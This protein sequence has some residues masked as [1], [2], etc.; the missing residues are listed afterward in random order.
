VGDGAVRGALDTY[1]TA[2]PP[3]R[4]KHRIEHIETLTDDDLPRFASLDVAA[5]MQPLHMEGLDDPTTPSFWVDGLSPG[6]YERGFRTADLVASG[7]TVPL[8]SDWMVA[9]FDPRVGMA[10][11]QLRRKPGRTERV[12]YLPEQA[13]TADQALR[14]YTIWAAE[15]A[16]DQAVYGRLQA[17]LRADVTALAED[18]L[19]VPP[20]DLPHVPV[21]LTVVD[22]NVVHRA[23]EVDAR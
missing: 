7:A 22:G 3:R 5:S 11:A 2:G 16:G 6:R 15:A 8:G 20:D 10:W 1:E 14:G 13:L 9:D 17:G 18:P 19:R 21:Q 23:P 4:G 12:P